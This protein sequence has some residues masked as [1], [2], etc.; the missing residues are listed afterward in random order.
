M[1]SPPR[2]GANEGSAFLKLDR[3]LSGTLCRLTLHHTVS[4]PRHLS[5]C[6][7]P[8]I[9]PS[10]LNPKTT[11]PFS[12]HTYLAPNAAPMKSAFAIGAPVMGSGSIA[13]QT[14]PADSEIPP[15]NKPARIADDFAILFDG[16]VRDRLI[17]TP[18]SLSA[19]VTGNA[20]H[21][22]PVAPLCVCC[23]I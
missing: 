11:S 10:A 4:P 21:A 7:P 16:R 13:T 14:V 1:Q 8:Q 17:R 9:A 19:T 23:G 15:A 12:P 22:H 3:V 6:P 5:G 2:N 20:K 18:A